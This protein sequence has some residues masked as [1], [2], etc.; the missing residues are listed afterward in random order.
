MSISIV[1]KY[2]ITNVSNK[3]SNL[4]FSMKIFDKVAFYY[5]NALVNSEFAGKTPNT[6]TIAV[7]ILTINPGKLYGSPHTYSLNV[8]TNTGRIFMT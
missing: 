3:I 6:S 8:K 2:F 1:F 7:Q 4:S 5:D